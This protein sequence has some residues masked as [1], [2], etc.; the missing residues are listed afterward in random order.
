[1]NQPSPHRAI[2]IVVV[3]AATLA[4]APLMTKLLTGP[5]D[6]FAIALWRTLLSVPALLVV[7]LT[8]RIRLPR[9][10]NAWISASIGGVALVAVPFGALAW[11]QL[12]VSSSMGGVLYGATPLLVAALAALLLRQERAGAREIAGA[13]IGLIGVLVLVGPNTLT[14]MTSLGLGQLITLAGPVSYAFGTVLLRRRPKEEALALTAGMYVVGAIVLLAAAALHGTEISIPAH[15]QLGQ[16][17]ILAVLGSVVPTVCMYLAIQWAGATRAA[18]AMLILPLFS[19]AYG[20]LFLS[21]VPTLTMLVGA[22]LIMAGCAVTLQQ[23]PPQPREG[24]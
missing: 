18:F 16:L 5:M 24:S 8:L 23:M 4:V 17:V 1:M 3:A 11:G 22:A 7:L 15:T 6:P 9:T 21:E 2:L 14:G 10:R 12:Y 20:W 19:L 13:V